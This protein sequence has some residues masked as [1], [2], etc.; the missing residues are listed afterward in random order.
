M[1]DGEGKS[2][3]SDWTVHSAPSAANASATA[4]LSRVSEK[5]AAEFFQRVE[6]ALQPMED[7]NDEFNID[8][9]DV[10][11]LTVSY[12]LYEQIPQGR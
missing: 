9:E 11:C 3:G 8:G 1:V 7:F 5:I 4:R 10:G 2:R 12:K 6:R